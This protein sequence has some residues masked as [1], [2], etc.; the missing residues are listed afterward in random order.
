M[1][2]PDGFVNLAEVFFR[3]MEVRRAFN[4]ENDFLLC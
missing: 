4:A 1:P 3:E 2:P